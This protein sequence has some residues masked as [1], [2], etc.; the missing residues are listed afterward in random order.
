MSHL[1]FIISLMTASRDW[2]QEVVTSRQTQIALLSVEGIGRRTWGR[3]RVKVEELELGFNQAWHEIQRRPKT[4]GLNARQS[5]AVEEFGKKWGTPENWSEYLVEQQIKVIL[6]E[7]EELIRAARGERGG[8]WSDGDL[9]AKQELIQTDEFY[10]P[11]LQEIADPPEILFVRGKLENLQAKLPVA[12][13]GTRRMTYYGK[14][15]SEKIGAEL[16]GAGATVV[17]GFMYG[18]DVTA[19][20][21]AVAAGG[22]TVGV[23]GFGFKHCFP[24]RQ[25]RLMERMIADGQTFITEYP[26]DV[27]A[28]EGTF[29][30]RNRIVAGMS[31]GTVVVEAAVRSGSLITAQ[32]A[33][34]AGREVMAVPGPITNPYSEGTKWLLSSGATLVSSGAEV[35]ARLRGEVGALSGGVGQLEADQGGASFS[36]IQEQILICLKKSP[37]GLTLEQLHDLTK[38]PAGQ[39]QSETMMLNLGQHLRLRGELIQIS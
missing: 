33:L 1:F 5:L 23:L 17:S 7:G 21:A 19:Q 4:F 3:I 2:I 35:V 26:P 32:L 18:I 11:L 16:A 37:L 28:R 30:E 24:P 8:K 20:K 25:T 29:P 9:L 36:P 13:V 6:R 15:C 10:P 31:W 12:V 22:K 39:L 14:D 34:D 27:R 38:I